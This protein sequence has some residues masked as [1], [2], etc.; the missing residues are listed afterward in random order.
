M[1]LITVTQEQL[2]NARVEAA[3]L[4]SELNEQVDMFRSTAGMEGLNQVALHAPAS[5]GNQNVAMAQEWFNGQEGAG[6]NLF[7]MLLRASKDE[8][9]NLRF[10]HGSFGSVWFDAVL[11]GQ[12]QGQPLRKQTRV[13]GA[14]Q[15]DGTHMVLLD[16]T[17][18]DSFATDDSE[19]T[20][21]WERC[22][23]E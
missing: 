16:A 2:D 14:R 8:M 4:A 20:M 3:R 5:Y 10:R 12:V 23:S 22:H 17:F 1:S 9:Q 11:E 13:T 7:R 21:T 19:D 6:R 15:P 18:S